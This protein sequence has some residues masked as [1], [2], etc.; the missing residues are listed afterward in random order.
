MVLSVVEVD[1]AQATYAILGRRC[2]YHCRMWE[3][4]LTEGVK[5]SH[6]DWWSLKSRRSRCRQKPCLASPSSLM[7]IAE[8]VLMVGLGGRQG[9]FI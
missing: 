5:R 2:W 1:G 6:S 8:I 9:R 7:R 3:V 4:V